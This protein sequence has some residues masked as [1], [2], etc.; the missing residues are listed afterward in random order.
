MKRSVLDKLHLCI[1]FLCM[2]S[3]LYAHDYWMSPL[4]YH[5]DVGSKVAVRLFVGDHFDPEIERPLQEKMTVTFL[6]HRAETKPLNLVDPK[7][8]DAKPVANLSLPNAGVHLLSMQ[9]DW[10]VI[11]MTGP[12][13]HQ[14]LEH[15]GLTQVIKQ[16]VDSGEADKPAVERYRRYLK[17]LIAVGDNKDQTWKKQLGHK[18]EIIPQSNPLDAKPGDKVVFQVLLD[19]KP[20]ANVQT[21]AM[22]RKGEQLTDVHAKTNQQGMVT[23]TLS[24]SGEWV[25]RLVHLRKCKDQEDIDYESFWSAITFGVR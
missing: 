19:G 16:R 14:Y 23:Y 11:E 15:E 17:S 18:L 1:F 10:A 13:F 4:K 3:T 12:K 22:G 8:F 2:Q 6:L 25:V 9:R 20:L 7:R 24:H 5:T 21:A